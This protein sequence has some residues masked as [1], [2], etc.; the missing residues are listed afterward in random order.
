MARDTH[1]RRKSKGL[2]EGNG[3]LRARIR[4]FPLP[5]GFPQ[6]IAPHYIP[7]WKGTL[8]QRQASNT[9]TSYPSLSQAILPQSWAASHS[10]PF[11]SLA[12]HTC[13]DQSH[14]SPYI[15][16]FISSEPLCFIFSTGVRL[17]TLGSLV[18]ASL[19]LVTSA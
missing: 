12:N 2:A 8:G 11:T 15:S 16:I 19:Q 14:G 3:T 7:L 13:P 10:A 9:L 18:R 4:C 5:P 1:I 6:S 17:D